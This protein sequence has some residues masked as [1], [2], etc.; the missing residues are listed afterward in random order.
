M[1][2][3]ESREPTWRGRGV[4]LIPGTWK[5][6][7]S[8]EGAPDPA[9]PAPLPGK[10]QVLKVSAEGPGLPEPDW[11]KEGPS[12]RSGAMEEGAPRQVNGSGRGRAAGAGR[13]GRGKPLAVSPASRCVLSQLLPRVPLPLLRA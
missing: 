1:F 11:W 7:G 3:M 4:V 8:R 10:F 6:S 9:A 13:V 5:A 2:R 12:G